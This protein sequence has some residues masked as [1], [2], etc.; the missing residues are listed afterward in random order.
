M[1]YNVRAANVVFWR[2]SAKYSW[3]NT[4]T[5]NKIGQQTWKWE[6]WKLLNAQVSLQ[7]PLFCTYMKTKT[8]LLLNYIQFSQAGITRNT[9]LDKNFPAWILIRV[10]LISH[11]FCVYRPGINVFDTVDYDISLS[12]LYAMKAMKA[13]HGESSSCTLSSQSSEELAVTS[14]VLQ[15]SILGSLLFIV[16]INDLTRCAKH[17]SVNRRRRRRIFINLYRSG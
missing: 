4:S 11:W 17:C 12:K 3:E 14:G 16:Y 8:V 1:I 10:E 7:N 5:S 9:T 13:F 6:M 2:K 15:G